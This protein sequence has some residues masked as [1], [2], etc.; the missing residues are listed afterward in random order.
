MHCDKHLDR[1][2]VLPHPVAWTEVPGSTAET[3]R[4]LVQRPARSSTTAMLLRR[5]SAG[6]AIRAPAFWFFEYYGPMIESGYFF[7]VPRVA[8]GSTSNWCT[9]SPLLAP[10]IGMPEPVRGARGRALRLGLADRCSAAMPFSRRRD[11]LAPGLRHPGKRPFSF[12]HITLYWRL[13]GLFDAWRG[14]TTWEKF[15]RVGFR[16]ETEAARG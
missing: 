2:R 10:G 12:R 5:G 14:K 13:R 3:A 7:S 15:A 9:P 16:T 8:V 1:D 6:S 11:V 4:P